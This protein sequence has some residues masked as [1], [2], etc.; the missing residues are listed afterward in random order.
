MMMM[1]MMRKR[2]R[3]EN[4]SD[5]VWYDFGHVVAVHLELSPNVRCNGLEQ[6]QLHDVSLIHRT[7]LLQ[8]LGRS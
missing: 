4:V 6:L 5:D 2:R 8:D 3:K 7:G 1:M